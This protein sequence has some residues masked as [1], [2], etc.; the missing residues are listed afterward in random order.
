[1]KEN[2]VVIGHGMPSDMK[3]HL[4][5]GCP[6]KDGNEPPLYSEQTK[7]AGD[8]CRLLFLPEVTGGSLTGLC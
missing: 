4:T 1:M 3:S 8:S 5:N 7:P 6:M 2:C